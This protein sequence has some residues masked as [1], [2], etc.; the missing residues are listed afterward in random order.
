[1]NSTRRT[2]IKSCVAAAGL[3]SVVPAIVSAEEKRR[4]SAPAAAGGASEDLK[5]PLVDPAKDPGA[6][7]IKYQHDKKQIK[8]ASLK[9]ERQGV[10]WESQSCSNC[11]LFTEVGKL[12]KDTVGKCTLIP[13]KLVKST[14]W[15]TSWT[16]KA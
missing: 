10:K 12:G 11:M 4:G 14:G 8:D 9:A 5:L 3:V 6:Q 13:G 2:F 16:K 1:M 15:S 7:A